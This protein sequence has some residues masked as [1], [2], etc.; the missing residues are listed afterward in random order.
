VLRLLRDVQPPPQHQ[1]TKTAFAWAREHGLAEE[2]ERRYGDLIAW[3]KV[4]QFESGLPILRQAYHP[5][6]GRPAYDPI[7]LLRL[8]FAR[9]AL[10]YDSRD[11]YVE[12]LHTEPFLCLLVGLPADGSIPDAQTLRR[13]EHRVTP[14][15][16]RGAVRQPRKQRTHDDISEHVVDFLLRSATPE[17]LPSRVD[18]LL[19]EIG[20]LPAQQA[21][22]FA[23]D[24]AIIGDGTFVDSRTSRHGVKFCEHGRNPCSCDRRFTDPQANLGWDHH[25]KRHVWG[26]LANVTT[27]DTVLGDPL[28]LSITM[29][30]AARHDGVAQLLTLRRTAD[31]YP[32]LQDR[33]CRLDSASGS[34]AHGR[35]IPTRGYLPIVALRKPSHGC[36]TTSMKSSSQSTASLSAPGASLCDRTGRS[37]GVSAG[38]APA[39]C[40][41]A[42]SSRTTHAT[43]PAPT[44]SF[45]PKDSY[46]LS[47]GLHRGGRRFGTLFAHRSAIERGLF[48]AMVA[49]S[50]LQHG[51]RVQ[52]RGRHHFDLFIEGLLAYARAFRGIAAPQT[53]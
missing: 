8:E 48:K 12:F 53:A 31:L 41:A 21:G 4:L 22:L 44:R 5:S 33:Y 23:K 37:M 39:R 7:L 26:F 18:H 28:P 46:C 42:A 17:H 34:E 15:G 1:L 43:N 16:R 27:L 51:S 40:R 25:E 11:A 45:L 6:L 36:T 24:A 35:Y 14:S 3:L 50:Q 19:R 32:E 29:D 38:S 30:G 20:F 9:R 13:F 10:R 47:G 2:F 52:S 49:D